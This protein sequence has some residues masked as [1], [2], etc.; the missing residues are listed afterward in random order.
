[1]SALNGT[2]SRATAHP[3]ESRNPGKCREK[4]IVHWSP[5]A[6]VGGSNGCPDGVCLLVS[7]LIGLMLRTHVKTKLTRRA[8]LRD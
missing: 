8:A 5:E 4:P 7:W 1:M 2:L 3:A 6:E